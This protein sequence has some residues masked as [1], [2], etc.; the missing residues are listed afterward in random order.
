ME[1]QKLTTLFVTGL[2]ALTIG[3][4]L[5]QSLLKKL[6]PAA[7]ELNLSI[8]Y[9]TLTGGLFLS[10][11]LILSKIIQLLITTLDVLYRSGNDHLTWESIKSCS[12]FVGCGIIWFLA[13]Y[14]LSAFL[15]DIIIGKHNTKDEI[16]KNNYP[17][18]I[19]RCLLL[20][21]FVIIFNPILERFLNLF[22]PVLEVGIYH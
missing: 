4:V 7:G 9:A 21:T 18:F 6:K 22:I 12:V 20:I 15:L 13:G 3:S 19:A 17:Y 10:Y 8:S 16:E 5:I 1:A 14:F 11:G 2:L